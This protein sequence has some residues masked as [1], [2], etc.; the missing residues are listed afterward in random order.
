MQ[1]KYCISFP[2]SCHLQSA[3]RGKITIA[4]FVYVSAFFPRILCMSQPNAEIHK[5]SIIG[6]GLQCRSARPLFSTS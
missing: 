3:S 5:Y 2:S 1:F 6:K 4:C